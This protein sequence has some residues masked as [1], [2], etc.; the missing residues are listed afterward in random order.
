MCKARRWSREERKFIDI[1][2]SMAIQIY[3][4]ITTAWVEWITLIRTFPTAELGWDQKND[5]GHFSVIVST[6]LIKMHGYC[7]NKRQHMTAIRWISWFFAGKLWRAWWCLTKGKSCPGH[8]LDNGKAGGSN[9][10]YDRKITSSVA[11]LLKSD[12]HCVEKTLEAARSA[13]WCFVDVQRIV[14]LMTSSIFL[15]NKIN[16]CVWFFFCQYLLVFNLW[17]FKFLANWKMWFESNRVKS[18]NIWPYEVEF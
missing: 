18:T 9:A 3:E 10:R 11:C 12:V 17:N 4:R 1:P 15:F 13:T 5:G 16:T 6:R 7:M 8:F 14:L 2:R